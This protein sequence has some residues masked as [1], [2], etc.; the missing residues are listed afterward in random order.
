MAFKKYTATMAVSGLPLPPIRVEREQEVKMISFHEWSQ[1]MKTKGMIMKRCTTGKTCAIA[2]VAALALTVAPMAMAD[3]NKGC[4]NATIKG[5]FVHTAA[6]FE[7]APPSIAGPV[8]G[9][10]TDTFDGNGHVVTSATI[11][12]NGNIIPVTGTG[13]YKVNPDCTGTYI[14]PGTTLAFV[15]ADSGNEIHAI[16]IDPGV[17]LSHTFRRQ[18]P[19]GDWRE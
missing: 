10:G 6:G 19:V 9:V 8:A 16:C 18:F 5:T 7:I 17:V 13:T 2:A 15:I 4:S 3:N 14:I 12:L 11:S 1:F